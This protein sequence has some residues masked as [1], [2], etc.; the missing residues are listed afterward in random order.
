METCPTPSTSL[1]QRIQKRIE[2]IVKEEFAHTLLT[3][4]VKAHTQGGQYPGCSCD[5]C[6]MKRWATSYVGTT[7]M[8]TVRRFYHLIHD[9]GADILEKSFWQSLLIEEEDQVRDL[10]NQCRE[11]KRSEVRRRLKQ[12]KEKIL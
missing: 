7:N 9:N 8:N 6:N 3:A 10:I 12:E 2:E 1:T 4:L 11:I 5:Y